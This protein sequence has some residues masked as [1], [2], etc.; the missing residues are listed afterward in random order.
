[1]ADNNC[2]RIVELLSDL[3]SR[4]L[5]PEERRAIDQHCAVCPECENSRRALHAAR[6]LLREHRPDDDA[7]P[8]DL[9]AALHRRLIEERAAREKEAKRP[10]F[11]RPVRALLGAAAC[12]FLFLLGYLTFTALPEQTAEEGV[13]L[14]R[15]VV[16][17][18]EP[19]TIRLTYTAERPLADVAVTIRLDDGIVFHTDDTRFRD[20]REYEWKGALK[21]GTNEIP[22]VVEVRRTG[23]RTIHTTAEF[24]GYRHRHDVDLQAD[25]ETI[26]VTYLSYGKRPI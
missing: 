8:G 12:A 2:A 13:V 21:A 18:K 14:S 1:M 17:A 5:T 15:S 16:N 10:L 20:L 23:T 11:G 19:L 7:V 24:D 26:T 9:R 4:E 6:T 25:G 22:F 3:L